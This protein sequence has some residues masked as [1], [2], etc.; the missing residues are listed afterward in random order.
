[1]LM[2]A[3]NSATGIKRNRSDCKLNRSHVAH[4]VHASALRT[5]LV[6]RCKQ[7]CGSPLLRGRERGLTHSRP[8][9]IVA[10]NNA[11]CLRQRPPSVARGYV[12][13]L[14]RSM[15][16]I[17]QNANNYPLYNDHI[18]VLGI[19][20]MSKAAGT[21]LKLETASMKMQSH[22]E[23]TLNSRATHIAA[24]FV[25]AA[26]LG[27][28]GGGGGGGSPGLNPGFV[29]PTLPEAI[30]TGANSGETSSYWIS[31]DQLTYDVF[32]VRGISSPAPAQTLT[33]TVTGVGLPLFSFTVINPAAFGPLVNS[34]LNSLTIPC[35]G[36]LHAGT[37]GSTV[38]SPPLP[39]QSVSFIYLDPASSAGLTYST[40]GLWSKPTSVPG[41]DVGG[42]LSIGMVTRPQDLPILP[43]TIAT[44]NG[45]MVGRYA[46]GVDTYLVG[47]NA[48][49]TATFTPGPNSTV[50]F[51][52][53]DTRIAQEIGGALDLS[54][55]VS[56][57]LLNLSG[58]L[59]YN[60]G[61]NSLTGTLTAP[62]VVGGPMTG[63]ATAKYYGPPTAPQATPA[64]FGGA[65]FVENGSKQMNGSF[66]LKK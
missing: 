32:T 54:P 51:S 31:G 56:Q 37:V 9:S 16:A 40:L 23:P 12:P 1:V 57:S 39:S 18:I 30:I 14:S 20:N 19:F 63:T 36:C 46:D 26:F 59:I 65:F 47:A 66:A 38:G 13:G 15:F 4:V 5:N 60:A 43:G 45:F 8:N 64:E 6:P 49:A 3:I 22:S 27:G 11:F 61:S 17:E 34:P 48:T 24:A 55:S 21:P 2:K 35:T 28:C 53:S 58:T 33:I 41:T 25:L 44:Y 29:Y 7:Q 62:G 10:F 50:T 52:T 42:A